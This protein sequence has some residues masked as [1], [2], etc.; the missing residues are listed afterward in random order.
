[1]ASKV[2]PLNAKAQALPLW[3]LIKNLDLN[4]GF[5]VQFVTDVGANHNHVFFAPPTGET[6]HDQTNDF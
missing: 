5:Q 3:A 1:V 4:A 6:T 2:E